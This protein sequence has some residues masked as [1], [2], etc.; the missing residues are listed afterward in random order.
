MR[1]RL[2]VLI[3]AIAGAGALFAAP[4]PV[5]ASCGYNPCYNRGHNGYGYGYQYAQPQYQQQYYYQPQYQ[6]QYQQPAY[7]QPPVYQQPHYPPAQ[8]AR[9]CCEPN[10]WD[11]LFNNN[12]CCAQTYAQP[13]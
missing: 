4:S 12:G 6:P 5:E 1:T 3:V 11:K 13:N 7:Y 10:F 2:A 8:Y 9:P